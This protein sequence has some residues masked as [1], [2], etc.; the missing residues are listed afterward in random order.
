MLD[1]SALYVG[2]GKEN[3]TEKEKKEREGKEEKKTRVY[4]NTN[5]ECIPAKPLPSEICP[6]HVRAGM[7]VW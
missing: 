6:L 7:F 2:A 1:E 5:A 3:E 4:V